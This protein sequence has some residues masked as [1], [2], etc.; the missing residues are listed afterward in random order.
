MATAAV[1]ATAVAPATAAAVLARLGFIHGQRPTVDFLLVQPG[2][3]GLRFRIGRHFDER[4]SF[5][6]HHG[7]KVTAFCAVDREPDDPLRPEGYVSLD[8][9]WERRGYR[10]EHGMV[11]AVSWKQVDVGH[12]VENRLTFWTRRLER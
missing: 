5:A 9:F 10:R 1:T 4:E 6:E 2:D 7:F 8:K 11:A 3:R 12:E